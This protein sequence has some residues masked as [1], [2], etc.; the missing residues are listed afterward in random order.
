MNY[1]DYFGYFASLVILIS[2]LSSSIK[3][4]RW[5]NLVGAILFTIY[6]ILI[7]SIPTAFMNF[8]IALIDIYFLIK[9]YTSKS[10]FSI[11]E[12]KEETTYFKNLLQFHKSDL[13]KFFNKSDFSI[14]QSKFAFYILKDMSPIGVFIGKRNGK[15]LDVE[16]DFVTKEYRDFKIGKYLYSDNKEMF[17]KEGFE[18][19]Q[20][21]TNN[22]LHKKYLEK[23]GFTS[24]GNDYSYEL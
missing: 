16:L 11:L 6:A 19:I 24:K 2:L 5:I 23:M 18:V 15:V 10:Y 22:E 3:K 20:C 17:V 14:D 4:L 21:T 12:I 1:L 13:I 7:K 8:A 9:I